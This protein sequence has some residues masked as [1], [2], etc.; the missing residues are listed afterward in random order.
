MTLTQKQKDKIIE[1]RAGI[2]ELPLCMETKNLQVHHIKRRNQK[3]SDQNNNILAKQLN[4]KE[5]L[6]DVC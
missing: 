1:E 5:T 4:D 6:F 2:C 3:G